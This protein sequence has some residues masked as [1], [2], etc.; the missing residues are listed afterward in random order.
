[1]ILVN[2]AFPGPLIEANW[3]DWIL[4]KL[5]LPPP[6]KNKKKKVWIHFSFGVILVTVNNLIEGPSEGTAIHWHGLL[7]KE[8]PWLDG[9]PGGESPNALFP[10]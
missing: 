4:G 7:Q 8:T 3:G 10:F 9:T 2:G 1:M 6:S 5:V